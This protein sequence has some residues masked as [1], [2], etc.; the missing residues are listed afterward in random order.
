[1]RH[2]W[3]NHSN[4]PPPPFPLQ[5]L[6]L[7]LE[8]TDAGKASRTYNPDTGKYSSVDMVSL[9]TDNAVTLN[10]HTCGIDPVVAATIPDYTVLATNMDRAGLPFVSGFEHATRPIYGTQFHP[11]KNN[12]EYGGDSA[13]VAAEPAVHDENGLRMAFELISFFVREAAKTGTRYDAA[14]GVEIVY[15][16]NEGIEKGDAHEETYMWKM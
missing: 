16:S 6:N 12:F 7:A 15:E 8:F 4:P 1:V 13:D 2:V 11:E 14:S 10:M 9:L 5:D 3:I